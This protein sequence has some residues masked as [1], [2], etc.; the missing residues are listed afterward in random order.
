MTGESQRADGSVPAHGWD[1]LQG[2]IAG[3]YRLCVDAGDPRG[4]PRYIAVA[5]SLDVRPYA[6]VTSDPAELLTALGCR[7]VAGGSAHGREPGP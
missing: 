4:K 7:N 6:V 3:R 5:R 1:A 2:Q